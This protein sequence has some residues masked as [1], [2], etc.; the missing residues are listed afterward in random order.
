MWKVMP[1]LLE[2]SRIFGMSVAGEKDLIA[3]R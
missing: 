1:H 3:S 2:I